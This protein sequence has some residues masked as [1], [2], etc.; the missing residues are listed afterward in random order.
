MKL[1]AAFISGMVINVIVVTCMYILLVDSKP[2]L[3]HRPVYT[4]TLKDNDTVILFF[5]LDNKLYSIKVPEEDFCHK[6]FG[7]EYRRNGNEKDK[8]HKL[9]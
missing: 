3:L 7:Y 8:S 2:N 5:T 1:F 4:T 9:Q 6:C